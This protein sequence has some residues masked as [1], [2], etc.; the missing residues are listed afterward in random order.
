[1]DGRPAVGNERALSMFHAGMDAMPVRHSYL[2]VF[3]DAASSSYSGEVG[4][5]VPWEMHSAFPSGP[6]SNQFAVP[7]PPPRKKK[8]FPLSY[9]GVV[10]TAILT[11]PRHQ[12]TLAEIYQAIEARFPDFT[13]NRVGW[14]NTVRHNLSLHDCF[15]KGELASHGRSSYWRVHPA[16]VGNF[17]RGDFRKLS[18]RVLDVYEK[19]GTSDYAGDIDLREHSNAVPLPFVRYRAASGEEPWGVCLMPSR[20]RA[21]DAVSPQTNYLGSYGLPYRVC[22]PYEKGVWTAPTCELPRQASSFICRTVSRIA[23]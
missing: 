9:V 6:S 12:L 8:R 1:M 7:V 5:R 22:T 14:K 17:S 10:A 23:R 21:L 2:D 16:Y 18:K 19:E 20:C 3:T 13:A 4:I 11:S 15:I